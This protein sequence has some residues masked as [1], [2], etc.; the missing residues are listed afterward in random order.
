MG[1]STIASTVFLY[2]IIV[3]Q[4][5]IINKLL[6]PENNNGAIVVHRPRTISDLHLIELCS[7]QNKILFDDTL[8]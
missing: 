3:D 2:A 1:A 7:V 6:A 8:F 5:S 4:P